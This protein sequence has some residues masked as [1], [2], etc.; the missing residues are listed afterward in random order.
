MEY[1]TQQ[2]MCRSPVFDESKNWIRTKF[3]KLSGQLFKANIIF[4]FNSVDC[5]KLYIDRLEHGACPS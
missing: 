4:L 3:I 2:F 1:E 5:L